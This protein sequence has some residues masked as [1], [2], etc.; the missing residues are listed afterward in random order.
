MNILTIVDHV[1]SECTA[2]YFL[3]D[4]MR[5]T[6]KVKGLLT[7]EELKIIVDNIWT[8]TENIYISTYPHMSFN[9]YEKTYT[10][11]N[12]T[13]ITLVWSPDYEH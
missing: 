4:L 9:F 1:H 2:S 12:F 10:D 3:S 11:D 8:T 6:V 13:V 7:E 5:E